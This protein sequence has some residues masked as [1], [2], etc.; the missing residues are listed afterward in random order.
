M[1]FALVVCCVYFMEPSFLFGMSEQLLLCVL[2]QNGGGIPPGTESSLPADV[3][4]QKGRHFPGSFSTK[5][6]KGFGKSQNRCLT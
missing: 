5:P 4:H 3:I 2:V 1:A 6:E